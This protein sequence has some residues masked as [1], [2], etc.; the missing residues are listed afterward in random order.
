M[1]SIPTTNTRASSPITR[2]WFREWFDSPFY[3]KLYFERN[4]KEAADFIHRLLTMLMPP[5]GSF[6][7]DVA[8]GRGRHARILAEQ[9]FDVTGIDLSPDSIAFANNFASDHLHFYVHD[10]R[11]LLCT[12]CFHYAFNFF[13]SFGFFETQREHLN[14]VHMVSAALKPK[15]VF[16]LDYLNATHVR[17]NLVPN[18]NRTIGDTIYSITRWCDG[19]HFYKRIVISDKTLESPLEYTEK[20]AVLLP[21]DFEALFQPNRLQILQLYGNYQLAPY[22]AQLSPRLLIIAEKMA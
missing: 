19:K 12:N 7:L 22:D 9:G 6:L 18:E 10:M 4:E 14:A 13:T 5:A 2:D 8:C 3:H 16:V 20:V 1:A 11:R 15:G 21:A 17:A